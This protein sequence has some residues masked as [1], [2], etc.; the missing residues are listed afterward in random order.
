MKNCGYPKIAQ[1]LPLGKLLSDSPDS[2][3]KAEEFIDGVSPIGFVSH[4]RGQ[5]LH[6]FASLGL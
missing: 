1:K 5:A 6:L 3:P 4:L 2:N